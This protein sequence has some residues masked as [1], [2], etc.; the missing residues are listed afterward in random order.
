MNP[1]VEIFIMTHNR[2][3]LLRQS[4][5]SVLSQDYDNFRV[6]VSDSSSDRRTEKSCLAHK[7]NFQYIRRGAL[8]AAKHAEQ[9][10]NEVDADYFMMFHDDDELMPDFLSEAMA[11][12]ARHPGA[13]AIGTN[14]R[15]MRGGR[16]SNRTLMSIQSGVIE[17]TSPE[18]FIVNYFPHTPGIAGP[19]AYPSY[20]YRK[21]CIPLMRPRP[22]RTADIAVILSTFRSG[23]VINCGKPLMYYR[24]HPQQDS[25]RPFTLREWLYVFSNTYRFTALNS[26]SPELLPWRLSV[27]GHWIKHEG[28]R[29][30]PDHYKRYGKVFLYLL[31]YFIKNKTAKWQRLSA[32]RR[33]G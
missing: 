8:T 5:A 29:A 22:F 30:L 4:L 2:P 25:T 28:I 23:S 16:K 18:A 14:A 7:G 15:I 1:L 31:P 11:L 10:R 19:A 32:W 3:D 26:R 6:I 9:I 13:A 27:W 20:V 33:K 12:F 21:K 17:Y 24:I